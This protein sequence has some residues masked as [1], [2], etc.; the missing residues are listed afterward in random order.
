MGK[1]ETQLDLSPSE[2]SSTGNGLHLI[3]LGNGNPQTTQAVA[4][5]I[6]CSQQTDSRE[7]PIAEDN[8]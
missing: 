8:I 5:T 3:E 1:T 6:G 4:Q 7:G 2:A